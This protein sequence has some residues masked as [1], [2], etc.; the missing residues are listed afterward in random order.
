LFGSCSRGEDTAESDIDLLI[1]ADE[2]DK[3]IVLELTD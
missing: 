1:I 3:D 2:L